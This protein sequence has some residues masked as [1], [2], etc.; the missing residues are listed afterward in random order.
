MEL[1]AAVRAGMDGQLAKDCRRRDEG[2]GSRKKR[3]IT[4]EGFTSTGRRGRRDG[5]RK[6]RQYCMAHTAS[7]QGTSD[8][9]RD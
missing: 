7:E 4:T 9:G 1:K 6:I 5:D 3:K 2:I 8:E